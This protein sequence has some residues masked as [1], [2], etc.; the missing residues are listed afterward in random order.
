MM[1]FTHSSVEKH[2]GCFQ[3]LDIMNKVPMNITI[4]SSVEKHVGCFQFLDIMNK[5]PMNIAEQPELGESCER[6]K[7]V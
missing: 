6:E 4:H 1:F 3:F 7:G 2:V 5:V